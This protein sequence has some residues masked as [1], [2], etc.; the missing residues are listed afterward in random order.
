M[1]STLSEQQK[2]E[3][4]RYCDSKYGETFCFC[5]TGEP[6]YMDEEGYLIDTE[7]IARM[8]FTKF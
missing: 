5:E 8:L 3:F 1:W 6:M 7:I 2:I 4:K